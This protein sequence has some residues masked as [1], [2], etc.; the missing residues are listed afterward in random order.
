MNKPR[1]RKS[2]KD[3]VII[4]LICNAILI[5][6]LELVIPVPIP[7]LGVK[8]GLANIITIV[9]IVF[10]SL[11]DVLTIVILKAIVVAVLSKG[12]TMLP[13]SLVGG[14]LSGIVM[15]FLYRKLSGIFSIKGISI[16]G[17][18][19]HNIAQLT[20]ASLILSEIIIW[21]YLP[22]LLISAVLTGLLTGSI[23]ELTVQEL[24]ERKIIPEL[25]E[26][27]IIPELAE[28]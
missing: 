16:F 25:Q 3:A 14:I 10:L 18:V 22:I 20:V 27:E 26:R 2:K 6:L 5:S 23:S 28:L 9:A 1:I 7:I 13:F 4:I 11:K 21:Y 19:T 24:Q 12:I 15:W 8:L 17:A